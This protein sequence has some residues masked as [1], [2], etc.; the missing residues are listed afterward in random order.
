[1][2]ASGATRLLIRDLDNPYEYRNGHAEGSDVSL[3]ALEAVVG[4]LRA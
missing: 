4:R 3:A 1:M 2:S